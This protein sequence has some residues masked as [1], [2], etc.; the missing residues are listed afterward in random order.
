M[1]KLILKYLTACVVLS[2]LISCSKDPNPE[3]VASLTIINALPGAATLSASFTEP[4]DK[5]VFSGMLPIYYGTYSPLNQQSISVKQQLL[6]IY[7]LP[8]TLAQDKPIYQLK[9]NPAPNEISTLFLMGKLDQPDQLM[10]IAKPPYYTV[11]DSVMGLR[12]V[13]LSLGSGPLRIK[14]SGSGINV[15]SDNLSYKGITDYIKVSAKSNIGDLEVQVFNQTSTTPI[16][17]YVMSDVGI[18]KMDNKWRF[19]NYTFALYGLPN[20]SNPTDAQKILLIN[21]F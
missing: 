6:S 3:G 8:D 18:T 14:I 20:A 10:V 15:T 21:D 2:V 16:A 12:F 11:A 17:S 1:K 13:N 19:R 4:S 5:K 7:K 9:V